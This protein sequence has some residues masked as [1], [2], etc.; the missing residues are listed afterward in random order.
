MDIPYLFGKNTNWSQR[1]ARPTIFDHIDLV[2]IYIGI[3]EWTEQG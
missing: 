2:K 3:S 1:M